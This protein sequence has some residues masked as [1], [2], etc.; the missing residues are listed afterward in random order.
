MIGPNMI[1]YALVA[2]RIAAWLL[3][4]VITV[5]SLVPPDYRP[6]TA[7]PHNLEHFAIFVT[8]GLCFG[9]GYSRSLISVAIGLIIFSGAIE[10]AQRLVH[11]RHARLSD[12]IVDAFAMCVG[13]V[14][15][16]FF[17]NYYLGRYS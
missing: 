15:G 8:T 16:S 2:A 13:V 4:S 11:G 6:E 3:A 5:L 17:A 7:V 10:L 9:I 1:S 14:V 12:F